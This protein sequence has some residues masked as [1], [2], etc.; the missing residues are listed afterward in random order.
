MDLEIKSIN[1]SSGQES[2]SVVL[3]MDQKD[4]SADF[5]GIQINLS[6]RLN[7]NAVVGGIDDTGCDTT[8]ETGDLL[9]SERNF[10]LKTHMSE[11]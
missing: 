10:E 7:L 3:D 9:V 5:E 11:R 6:I 1:A 4:F 2:G 8:V